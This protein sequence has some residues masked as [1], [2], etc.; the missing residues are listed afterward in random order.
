MPQARKGPKRSVK[1]EILPA[2]ATVT[3][4]ASEASTEMVFLFQIDFVK[5]DLLQQWG[6]Y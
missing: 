1:N 3:P 5:S 2:S 6:I 4:F